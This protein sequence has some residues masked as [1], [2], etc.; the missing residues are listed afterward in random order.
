MT[1]E[2]EGPRPSGRFQRPVIDRW[3]VD[4]LR[5]YIEELRA[6]IIRAEG[7]IG[8]RQASRA[9]ADLFFRKPSA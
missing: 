9:A 8:K 3:D 4:E 7:E 1:M 2:E 5:A 6:E